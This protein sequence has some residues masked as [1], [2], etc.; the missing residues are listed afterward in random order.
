M[1]A[2]SRETESYRVIWRKVRI[3]PVMTRKIFQIGLPSALQM[4]VTSVFQMYLSSP[5]SIIL[6]L[7]AMAGAGPLM[8][9]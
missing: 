3:N 6:V 2:L 7:L 1:A 9:K 8:G 4:A 5:I